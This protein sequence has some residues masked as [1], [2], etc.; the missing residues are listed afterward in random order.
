VSYRHRRRSEAQNGIF[1]IEKRGQQAPTRCRSCHFFVGI[2]R[3]LESDLHL[4]G[5][6]AM[7]SQLFE[8]ADGIVKSSVRIGQ[9]LRF[10][11]GKGCHVVHIT[12]LLE[13]RFVS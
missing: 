9:R 7:W 1:A 12:T 4:E 8:G 10:G 11:R 6:F 13:A 2:E 3:V 5:P